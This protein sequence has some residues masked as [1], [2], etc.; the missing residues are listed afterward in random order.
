M[1]VAMQPMSR[2]S[3]GSGVTV[4]ADAGAE[5]RVFPDQQRMSALAQLAPPFPF[6]GLYAY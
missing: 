6:L 1:A 5:Q 2:Q 4:I 3:S